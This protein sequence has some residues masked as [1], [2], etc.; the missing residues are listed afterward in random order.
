MTVVSGR[1]SPRSQ[2][3]P[4]PVFCHYKGSLC[5]DNAKRV[6]TNRVWHG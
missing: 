1:I 4:T 5:T 3:L 2:I 6:F